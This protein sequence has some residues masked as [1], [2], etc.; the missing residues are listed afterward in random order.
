MFSSDKNIE[1]FKD[2]FVEIRDYLKLQKEY[3]GLEI[4]E[5]V[6]ILI[7][8]LI[9]G[10]L[11]IIL[12]LVALFYLLF[13][14][15]YAIEPLVGGLKYSYCIIAGVTIVMMLIIYFFRQKLIIAPI[16]KFMANL[17]INKK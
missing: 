7:S 15:A 17:F 2:L 3:V 10:F 4:I 12:G 11:L 14:L 6:T 5:K 8:T 16:V 13:A 9:V 1:S